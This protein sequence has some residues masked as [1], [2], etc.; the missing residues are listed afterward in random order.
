ME[1]ERHTGSNASRV[2]DS[3]AEGKTGSADSLREEAQAD[4][5]ALDR[6]SIRVAGTRNSELKVRSAHQQ[7]PIDTRKVNRARGVKRPT[8][9]DETRR[10]SE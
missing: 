10:G 9:T 6:S 2:K 4:S 7:S 3:R 5:Q 8:D 1:K